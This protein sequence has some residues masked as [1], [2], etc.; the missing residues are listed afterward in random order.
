MYHL[1]VVVIKIN[2]KPEN[3]NEKAPSDVRK[4]KS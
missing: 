3:K 1:V 4:V 2:V